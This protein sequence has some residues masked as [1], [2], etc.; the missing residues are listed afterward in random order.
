MGHGEFEV[1]GGLWVDD[2][3]MPFNPR[4]ANGA[5]F[6]SITGVM[7]FSFDEARLLPR[8]PADLVAE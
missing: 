5:N 4:P 8:G 6:T 2:D 1:T 7:S 3:L